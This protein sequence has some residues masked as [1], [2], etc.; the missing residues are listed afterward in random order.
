L[1]AALAA[2]E[3]E[4]EG[5]RAELQEVRGKHDM[6]LG[7][8]AAALVREGIAREEAKGWRIMAERGQCAGSA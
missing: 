4:A 3:R 5:L 6:L 8:V 7:Q 2:K 1:E